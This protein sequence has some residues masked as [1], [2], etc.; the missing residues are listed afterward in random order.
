[1]SEAARQPA[2]FAAMTRNCADSSCPSLNGEELLQ[3]LKSQRSDPPLPAGGERGIR[4]LALQ[5]LQQFLTIQ[6]GA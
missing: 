1:M 4:S 2:T 3:L 5:Q 6:A